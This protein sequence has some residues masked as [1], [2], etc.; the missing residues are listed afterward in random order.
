MK[1]NPRRTSKAVI[2]SQKNEPRNE[3]LL[4]ADSTFP[5]SP[6][7]IR[8]SFH[9]DPKANRPNHDNKETKKRSSKKIK[10]PRKKK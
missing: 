4:P 2:R 10:G 9:M 6:E 5:P 3:P 8:F 1:P 7:A